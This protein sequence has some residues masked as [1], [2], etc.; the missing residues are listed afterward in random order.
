MSTIQGGLF[1]L[2]GGIGL[3]L[4]G[5][6]VVLEYGSILRR[7]C[8]QAAKAT[9]YRDGYLARDGGAGEAAA[10]AVLSAG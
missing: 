8:S 7:I 2:L 3:F 10:E 5:M 9:A 6:V 4:L 1:T